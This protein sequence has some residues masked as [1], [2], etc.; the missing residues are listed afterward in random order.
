MTYEQTGKNRWRIDGIDE[1]DASVLTENTDKGIVL[2]VLNNQSDSVQGTFCIDGESLLCADDDG[3]RNLELRAESGCRYVLSIE[4][5]GIDI[6]KVGY[7]DDPEYDN[8]GFIDYEE[9]KK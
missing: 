1:V 9:D 7:D 8:I 2:S 5:D 3:D 6:H 4:L